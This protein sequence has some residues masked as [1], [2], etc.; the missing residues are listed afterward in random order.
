VQLSRELARRGHETLHLYSAS[1]ETGKGR[2]ARVEGDPVTFEV[3]P[4]DLGAS[5][6]KYSVLRRPVQEIQYGRL[7]A[8]RAARFSPEV[9]LSGN[10][11]LLAQ[12]VLLPKMKRLGA[13][14]VFWQQDIYSAGMTQAAKARIPLVGGSLG[15]V[16]RAI[17]R[18]QLQASDAVVVISDD[19]RPVLRSWGID[20]A[21]VT[22]IENWAPHGE[23]VP[24]PRDNAWARQHGLEGV[25][26]ILYAGT[27]GL[28]HNPSL[29]LGLA[30]R[31]RDRPDVRVVVVSSGLGADWLKERSGDL[32]NL[33]LLPFQP[34]DV[35]PQVLAS[36]DVLAAILEPEAGVFSVPSK[37]LSYH[38][39]GRPLLAAIPAENLAA[40]LLLREGTGLLAEPG[41]AEGFAVAAE[42]LIDAP[43][44]RA[45]MGERALAYAA[46]AFDI[47]TIAD[48]FEDV[49]G[50]V[51]TR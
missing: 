6:D 26:T 49:L 13:R 46:T 21:K 31:F 15:T 2:L 43:E 5:F 7:A 51:H 10:T 39:A 20:D 50:R 36:G 23:I 19:F 44:L 1:F 8:A 42:K 33:V 32:P 3:E 28:K 12:Q 47:K 38:C 11:P 16:F 45:S 4:V 34:Y 27:L 40:R 24:L 29:L 17:E 22:V 35:L 25:T 18:R 41:D 37:V 48:R 30:E 9:V 14:F